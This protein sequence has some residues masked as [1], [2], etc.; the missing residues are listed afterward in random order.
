MKIAFIRF[1]LPCELNL[2]TASIN[3]LGTEIRQGLFK[4]WIEDLGYELTIYSGIPKKDVPLMRSSLIDSNKFRWAKKVKYN[5]KQTP[6][7]EDVLF[8]EMGVPNTLYSY[9]HD[10][11]E[12]SYVKRTLECIND[13]Q[14]K[15][16]YY[17]H[18]ILPFPF[19]LVGQEPTSKNELNLKVMFSKV[20]IF[21]DKS[22]TI[23][24]HFQNQQ[25]WLKDEYSKLQQDIFS[26]L[27]FKFIPLCYSNID[28]FYDPNSNPEWDCVFIGAQWDSASTSKGQDRTDEIKAFYDTELYRTALIGKWDFKKWKH[29]K[30]LGHLGFH[31]DAYKYWNNSFSCVWTTSQKVK[32]WGLIPTR[33]IMVIR[34]GSLCLADKN[35]YGVE[36]VIGDSYIVSNVE[37]VKQKLDIYKA[38]NLG[39]R[40]LIQQA[41]L[42]KF[43]Q[44][45]ELNWTEIFS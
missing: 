21:K 29:L 40:K 17:Q 13:F 8:I 33:P 28:P 35:L 39:E 38:L 6:T 12:I 25:E 10:N 45:K 34:A 31:G 7:K 24:H 15:V 19:E 2:D 18:G 32:R 4:S 23:L 11:K 1:G 43:K 27:Y 30:Y 36:N 16:I 14:G 37:E 20:D 26:K 44:W 42:E 22:W 3:M 41:Q 5:L 9:E